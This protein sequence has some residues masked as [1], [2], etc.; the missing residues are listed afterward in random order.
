MS[1]AKF[2]E[3]SESPPA[4]YPNMFALRLHQTDPFRGLHLDREEHIPVWHT[5][6]RHTVTA[7][8]ASQ[9]IEERRASEKADVA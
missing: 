4:R 1:C 5:L 8:H 9:R 6:D 3:P 7:N 2:E